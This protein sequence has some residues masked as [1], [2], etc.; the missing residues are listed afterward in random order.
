MIA[1]CS[2]RK[3]TEKF[4]IIKTKLKLKIVKLARFS[5]RSSDDELD[6]VL[7]GKKDLPKEKKQPISSTG[8]ED[9][10]V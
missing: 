10:D 3:D 1:G 2:T 8:S 5:L 9:E 6:V 7:D 4:S